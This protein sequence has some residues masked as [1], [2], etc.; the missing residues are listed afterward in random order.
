M[1][2][3]DDPGLAGCGRF[4][5]GGLLAAFGQFLVEDVAE[6]VVEEVEDGVVDDGVE[7]PVELQV[8]FEGAFFVAGAAGGDHFVYEFSEAVH[9]VG[10][11][12]PRRRLR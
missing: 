9:V 1:D 7:A 11:G 4:E 10:G 6:A 3:V 8:G 5:F 2:G 12:E